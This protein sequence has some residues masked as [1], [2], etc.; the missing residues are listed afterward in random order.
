MLHRSIV[1][2]LAVL[3][4]GPAKTAT[5]PPA[6]DPPGDS[7]ASPA[8]TAA[9]DPAIAEHMRSAQK[10]DRIKLRFD[11]HGRIV[12]Q[13]LYHGD[14]STIGAPAQAAAAERFPGAET[15]FYENEVYA[16]LGP[17]EEIEVKT[18]DG[19]RCEIAAKPD[20]TVIYEECQMDASALPEPVAAA[21]AK[22]APGATIEEAEVKKRPEGDEY[23]VEVTVDG[24]SQYLRIRSDGSL[25]QRLLRVPAIVEIPL[26]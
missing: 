8:G 22:L 14:A 12:K 7:G 23:T 11:E 16:D 2:L 3:A 24:R 15:L 19:R 6:A 25:I 9:L 4:C 17:V 20:G 21:V 18:K 1:P 13:S 26:P 10:V 5:T